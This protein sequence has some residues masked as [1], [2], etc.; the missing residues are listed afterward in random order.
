MPVLYNPPTPDVEVQ[1]DQT[2][3]WVHPKGK[4][5][6]IGGNFPV[7]APMYQHVDNT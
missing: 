6:N 1:C 4:L 7:W 5:G 3:F 2:Y